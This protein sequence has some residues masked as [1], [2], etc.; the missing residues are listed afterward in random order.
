MQHHNHHHSDK[1]DRRCRKCPK[2]QHDEWKCI[3]CG[4]GRMKC[5]CVREDDKK[6][7]GPCW[8]KCEFPCKLSCDKKTALKQLESHRKY[9]CCETPLDMGC[10]TFDPFK[11]SNKC[12]YNPCFVRDGECGKDCAVCEPCETSC[13]SSCSSSSSEEECICVV[14]PAKPRCCP[15][16]DKKEKKKCKKED[17]GCGDPWKK[18]KHHHKDRCCCDYR[19]RRVVTQNIA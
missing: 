1:S 17:C 6:E 2:V 12:W 14:T 7:C 4:H 16:K 13:S 11:I 8:K 5:V 3:D 9:H 18:K 10:R 19:P 15:K